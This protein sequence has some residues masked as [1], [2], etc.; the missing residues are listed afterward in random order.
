M[1]QAKIQTHDVIGIA[2]KESVLDDL[3]SVPEM[4][5]VNIGS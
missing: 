5:N 4:L 2:E 3:V 1:L